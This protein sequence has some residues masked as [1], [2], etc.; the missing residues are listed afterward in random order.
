[1]LAKSRRWFGV[2]TLVA[3]APP[4]YAQ[5]VPNV[6]ALA[7]LSPVIMVLLAGLL[8]WLERSLLSGLMHVSLI[9]LWVIAFA[10]LAN[11]VTT[12]WI[13]WTPIGIYGVH[14]FYIL[15]KLGSVAARRRRAHRSGA[16]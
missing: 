11:T 8:G 5:Q 16:A 9:L 6:I 10:V 3:A 2:A 13:I 12:D 7:S 1:M 4:V 14:S 15:Y